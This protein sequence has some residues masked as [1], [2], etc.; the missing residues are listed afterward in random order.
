[1]WRKGPHRRKCWGPAPCSLGQG[2]RLSLLEVGHW[3]TRRTGEV[4][5]T[6][7]NRGGGP[8]SACAGPSSVLSLPVICPSVRKPRGA[9]QGSAPRPRGSAALSRDIIHRALESSN[10]RPPRVI[11]VPHQRAVPAFI[12]STLLEGHV[13]S[14]LGDYGGPGGRGVLAPQGQCPSHNPA[15]ELLLLCGR[16]VGAPAA[17]PAV[18][19]A[20]C[21]GSPARALPGLHGPQ[22]RSSPRLSPLPC[23]CG[24]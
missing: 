24:C 11:L 3:G 9:P 10:F 7:S 8:A 14:I 17:L 4:C 13:A 12:L 16:Q 1:M 20:L 18:T 2:G 5:Q 23:L 6:E 15:P 21:S 19:S 22:S